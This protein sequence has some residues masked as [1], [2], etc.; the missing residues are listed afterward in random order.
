MVPSIKDTPKMV[1]KTVK[2]SISS[3]IKISTWVTGKMIDFMVMDSIYIPMVINTKEN[4]KKDSKK[5]G[6]FIFI[7]V[8]LLI[9]DN[10]IMTEKVV[11]ELTSMQ[12]KKFILV[13]G[14]MAKNTD[15]AFTN[16]KMGIN[17]TENGLRIKKMVLVFYIIKVELVIMDNGLMIKP[18]IMGLS[19]MLI[20]MFMMGIF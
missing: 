10:G 8:E 13:A 3:L 12:I 2:E 14:L 16:I 1:S 15:M 11:Q 18:V 6:A 9:K 19:L 20:K 4:F 5:E 7:V 17:M